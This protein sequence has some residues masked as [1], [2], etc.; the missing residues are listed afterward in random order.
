MREVVR[1]VPKRRR[2]IAV[3]LL[4]LFVMAATV[5]T[6]TARTNKAGVRTAIKAIDSCGYP[7]ANSTA[8]P[9]A[10]IT[11]NEST[12][13]KGFNPKTGG[14][15]GDKIYAYYSDEHAL[16]LGGAGA[17][18]SG[19]QAT[20]PAGST[21]KSID[22][23]NPNT[24]A[25][26]LDPSNRPLKPIL[27]VTDIT[28]GGTANSPQ[29]GD[30]QA[31]AL[32]NA[33]GF[34]PSEV[35][36]SFKPAGAADPP[37]NNG[38]LGTLGTWATVTGG[39]K[40]E[41]FSAAIVWDTASLGLTSGHIYKLQFMVH[42]GDQN[43]A[44]GDVGEGCTS[45]SAPG[46]TTVASAG[47]FTAAG[48]ATI[49]DEAT[50]SGLNPTATGTVVFKAFGPQ[51]DKANP[52][53]SGNQVGTTQT[54]NL[55]QVNGNVNHKYNASV[56][57]SAAGDYTWTVDVFV[58]AL[59]VAS[60]GCTTD[61]AHETSTPTPAG[62]TLPTDAGATVR[63][64]AN[65]ADLVDTGTLSGGTSDAT[66]TIT[67]QLFKDDGS[68][69]CG[70][71]VT[72]PA[73][74]TTSTVAGANGVKYTSPSVNV[75]TAGTYHW[76]ANYGGDSKNDKTSNTCNG[77][78]ENVDVIDPQID[79]SKSPASQSVNFN[80]T[81]HFTIE[82]TNIGSV[83]LKDIVVT[84][85]QAPNCGRTATET[86]ALIQAKYGAGAT[87]LLPKQ[88]F[89][90]DCSLSFV[91][92]AFVNVVGACGIDPLANQVCDTDTNGGTPGQD[93]PATEAN[94]CANVGI[95]GLTTKQ[96][97]VPN[98]KASLSGTINPNG[99]ITFSLYKGACVPANQI[100]NE[101]QTVSANGS[102][103]TVNTDKLTALLAAKNLSTETAGTYNW[104]ITYT[105]D[106]HNN[107]DIIGTCGAENFVVTNG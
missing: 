34:T 18:W 3:A 64:G 59:K 71:E 21:A 99:K 100:Y 95:E 36:G 46:V 63:L 65:G 19:T 38:S 23:T 30:W 68:G 20:A 39:L 16:T 33:T 102:F 80:G 101:E 60:S 43:Q 98:D 4:A 61:P 27:Y 5:P 77:T 81:A 44:G 76:I 35:H 62:P 91:Q 105:G 49:S 103:D 66:G 89:K 92:A 97:F 8:F 69:G 11:F 22:N 45:A 7:V 90:Y 54:V 57:V 1:K 51:A 31:G 83:P 53:C 26:T 72:D 52:V 42:D 73:N 10:A 17:D 85:D 86:L 96:N 88:S 75:K 70:V 48:T 79:V 93:C 15:L 25:A 104:L 67:W 82:V 94:R 37:K 55:A 13:L 47:Q 24:G 9:R 32:H 28:A 12:V 58:G 41:G 29:S 56:S 2:Y 87:T 6:A 14:F 107:D 78:K 74:P 106:T 84:D 40:D 50:V